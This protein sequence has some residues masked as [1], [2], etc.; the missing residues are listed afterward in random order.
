MPALLVG[1]LHRVRLR[2]LLREVLSHMFAWPIG[3]PVPRRATA[4]PRGAGIIGIPLIA[5][6]QHQAV[7]SLAYLDK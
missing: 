3:M 5:Q 7:I 6:N 1:M 4:I 2:D